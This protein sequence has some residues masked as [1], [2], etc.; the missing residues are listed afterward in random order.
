MR[1]FEIAGEPDRTRRGHA[2]QRVKRPQYWVKSATSDV[3]EN[4]STGWFR[5]LMI[6][7]EHTMMNV[8]PAT[9]HRGR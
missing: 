6:A 5:D 8:T 4:Q 7:M 9:G 2:D 3:V 1:F